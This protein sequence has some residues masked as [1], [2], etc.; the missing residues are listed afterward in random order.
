MA[1]QF[2]R[3]F[4][5]DEEFGEFP[6]WLSDLNGPQG[7]YGAEITKVDDGLSAAGDPLI[8]IF[9]KILWGPLGHPQYNQFNGSA[10][11]GQ[12][13][14]HPNCGGAVMHFLHMIGE[15]YKGKCLINLD[16]WIGKRCRVKVEV[17]IP[18]GYDN[19]FWSV[20]DNQE[21]IDLWAKPTAGLAEFKFR[22]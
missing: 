7:Y 18:E 3:D 22:M 21:W 16:K 12:V 1:R 4:S 20:V 10:I 14:F 9:Y 5:D 19:K 15:P 8:K 11:T 17:A 13:S 2:K 6:P